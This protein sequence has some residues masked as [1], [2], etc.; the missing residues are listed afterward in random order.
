MSEGAT[1]KESDCWV[2]WWRAETIERSVL[3]SLIFCDLEPIPIYQ[4]KNKKITER[5]TGL[6]QKMRGVDEKCHWQW[7]WPSVISSSHTSLPCRGRRKRF[8][9]VRTHLPCSW[10]DELEKI[11]IF[12]ALPKLTWWDWSLL[13][14]CLLPHSVLLHLNLQPPCVKQSWQKGDRMRQTIMPQW[15]SHPSLP[16]QI[17]HLLQPSVGEDYVLVG[18]EAADIPALTQA[19]SHCPERLYTHAY[20]N[21]V[22]PLISH[23]GCIFGCPQQ[24]FWAYQ[25]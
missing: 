24:C 7:W 25:C 8:L 14:P 2:D 12:T 21:A 22:K 5:K 9:H 11:C 16:A 20:M 4:K 19:P 18:Y 23:E 6:H 10:R 3:S 13:P 15:P 17:S 1:K